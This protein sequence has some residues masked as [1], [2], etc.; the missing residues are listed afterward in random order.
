MLAR[1][2]ILCDIPDAIE[3]IYHDAGRVDL[4]GRSSTIHET[5][6]DWFEE[7]IRRRPS[8]L[9]LD[10]LDQLAMPENEVCVPDCGA[11]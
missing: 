5:L 1:G 4:E 7:A 11:G 8:L 10:N 6:S 9:I 2:F 3:P